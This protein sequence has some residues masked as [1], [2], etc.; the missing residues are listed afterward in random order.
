MGVAVCAMMHDYGQCP[1]GHTGEKAL[2]KASQE[3]NGGPVLHNII[4]AMR[5]YFRENG[6]IKKAINQGAIVEE[7]AKRRLQE[8]GIDVNH[9]DYNS[10]LRECISQIESDLDLGNLPELQKKIEE[11]AKNNGEKKTKRALELIVTSAGNHNGERGNSD[12]IPDYRANSFKDFLSRM[13]ETFI[14]NEANKRLPIGNIIEAIV[15]LT[16]QISSIPLDM[17][18]G[19]ISGIENVIS[20]DWE[21]PVSR[22]LGISKEEVRKGLDGN[23]DVLKNLAFDL[24]A[25]FADDVIENS[26]PREIHMSEEKSSLLYGKKATAT[27]PPRIGIRTPNIIEHTQHTSTAEEEIILNNMFSDLVDILVKETL[28]GDGTPETKG[29]AFHPGLN[30]IFRMEDNN[31]HRYSN[32]ERLRQYI[33][34]NGNNDLAGFYEYCLNT[35]KRQ[36]DYL[37]DIVRKQEIQYFRSMMTETAKRYKEDPYFFPDADRGSVK[38]VI[39]VLYQPQTPVEI[40]PPED[41]ETY[42]DDEIAQIIENMNLYL[43]DNPIEGMKRLETMRAK[44]KEKMTKEG[45][46][47]ETYYRKISRDNQIAAHLAIEYLTTLSD[48][49][50]VELATKLKVIGKEELAVIKSKYTGEKGEGHLGN[51]T[52]GTIKDYEEK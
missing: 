15:K 16:D 48:Y 52:R 30:G 47:T 34:R 28:S 7:E 24:Q 21:I 35:S 38:R 25:I 18:D 51:A 11:N 45:R 50:V 1:F 33:T 3:H 27:E 49:D 43:E 10:K 42:T 31:P 20:S 29:K 19:R 4:G 13:Q 5:L 12:I 22:I 9:K 36:Y 44:T 40:L 39:Q 37:K 41:G 26:N 2:E 17:V 8:D 46:I 32:I 14:D 6:K 23:D